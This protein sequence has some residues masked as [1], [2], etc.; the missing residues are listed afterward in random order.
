MFNRDLLG[1]KTR[2]NALRFERTNLWFEAIK[3][4]A[5]VWVCTD[6]VGIE[7]DLVPITCDWMR[8]NNRPCQSMQQSRAAHIPERLYANAVAGVK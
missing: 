3:R 2:L 4:S 8:S 7:S 6:V 5:P 1:Q